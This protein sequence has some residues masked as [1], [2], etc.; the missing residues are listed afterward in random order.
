MPQSNY[1]YT[2]SVDFPNGKVDSSRLANEIRS[3]QIV[4]ALDYIGTANDTC[5]IWFKDTLSL[6]D[7]TTLNSIV[8]NHS[9]ESLAENSLTKVQLYSGTNAVPSAAS[10][11]VGQAPAKG[12]GGFAP[13]PKNNPYEPYPDEI[14]SLYVDGEGSLIT[15][16]A[17]LTDEGSI[18]EDFTGSS[19][20]QNLTGTLTFTNGSNLV[21]GYNTLFSQELN[22]DT[23]IRPSSGSDW[24]KIVRAPNDTQCQIDTPYDGATAVNVSS[25]KTRWISKI[26]GSNPGTISISNSCAN[27][28]S[29]VDADN[30]S[31]IY[32]EGDYLPMTTTFVLAVSQ[33]IENQ[34][35]FFGVRDDI[36]NPSMYCD[37]LLDGY[38]N[39]VIKFRSAWNGD[40]Q[41]SIIPLPSGL[42]TSLD[43][44]YKIDIS[45]EYC[46]LAVN[47]VLI[48]K[49]E[50]HIPDP[51]VELSICAGILNNSSVVSS[52]T[53]SVDNIF[54]SNQDQIQISNT[55]L[56]PLPIVSKEDQHTISS[57]LMTTST[58]LNQDIV[59]YTVPTGK[60][61]YLVG[62]RVECAGSID[63]S[64][65]IGRNDLS[66]E[67]YF[68]GNVDCNLFRS[69]TLEAGTNTGEIDFSTPRKIGV[70]G[71]VVKITVS[72]KGALSCEWHAV[73][74]FV[75][76]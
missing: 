56:S 24:Y 20:E 68:P 33:R 55:F 34:S 27:I 32:R 29:G 69:F 63:G 19:L 3:S 7:E 25:E 47:G 21:D 1:N 14:V 42:N 11:V 57:R 28:S 61:F 8:A 53:V 46:A 64:I 39:T 6:D 9:G 58:T 5:S 70:G 52:T 48:A 15:R 75:L 26:L 18:R 35:I 59:N 67:P 36:D 37:I 16:G 30:L 73:M 43:L 44:R 41:E 10:G 22:R 49:H 60:V 40:K 65:K 45:S 12:L 51:Y 31:L 71:D 54:F 50:N 13:D 74:D 17:S 72:P 4:I 2:I 66:L 38:D 23:Y 76:R 62:Y